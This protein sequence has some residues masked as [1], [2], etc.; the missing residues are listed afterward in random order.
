MLLYPRFG[1][2]FSL[3]NER[4]VVRY[5]LVIRNLAAMLDRAALPAIESH[6][7]LGRPCVCSAMKAF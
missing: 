6:V 7:S 3:C 1:G 2:G 4:R 5:G